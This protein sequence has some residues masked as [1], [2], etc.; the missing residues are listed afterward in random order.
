MPKILKKNHLLKSADTLPQAAVHS[1]RHLSFLTLISGFPVDNMVRVPKYYGK[2]WGSYTINNVPSD[3][4][5][6]LRGTTIAN[7]MH[8]Y[9]LKFPYFL[10]ATRRL[11]LWSL[12]PLQA[13]LREE[14]GCCALILGWIYVLIWFLLLVTIAAFCLPLEI[15]GYIF[16]PMLGYGCYLGANC[17]YDDGDD[18]RYSRAAGKEG[19]KDDGK[20]DP[21]S[22]CLCLYNC[23]LETEEYSEEDDVEK[24]AEDKPQQQ[25]AEPLHVE[26]Q[27]DG[28]QGDAGNYDV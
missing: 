13:V 2:E 26:V 22:P 11:F 15:L 4:I 27:A 7:Y 20:L 16:G 1:A 25:A 10:N 3:S 8:M 23:C 28:E 19:D 6:G 12:D 9:E 14:L 17:L 24:Q 5:S 21:K 18:M